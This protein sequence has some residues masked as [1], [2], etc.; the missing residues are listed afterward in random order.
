MVDTQ[1]GSNLENYNLYSVEVLHQMGLSDF[2]RAVS[3]NVKKDAE[4][5]PAPPQA[6]V[7]NESKE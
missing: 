1:I 5:A 2:G 3:S 7:E 6:S 4:E